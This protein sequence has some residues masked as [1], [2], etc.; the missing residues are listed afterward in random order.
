MFY[1]GFPGKDSE[2]N[3]FEIRSGTHE[4]CNHGDVQ[5]IIFHVVGTVNTGMMLKQVEL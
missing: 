4:R 3:S 1:L 5:V 2:R